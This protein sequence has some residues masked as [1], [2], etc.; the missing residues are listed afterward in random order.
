MVWCGVVWC[1]VVWCGVLWLKEEYSHLVFL[2]LYGTCFYVWSIGGLWGWFNGCGGSGIDVA[3][4][5]V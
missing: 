1:G 4:V 5:A 3:V 2:G